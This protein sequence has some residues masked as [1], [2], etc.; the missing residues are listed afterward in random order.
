MSGIRHLEHV[1]V[2]RDPEGTWH[3][4]FPQVAC[5]G[6]DRLVVSFR[7]SPLREPVPAYS[8]RHDHRDRES[9][10]SLVRSTDGGR[11]WDPSTHQVLAETHGDGFIEQCSVTTL[12]DNTLLFDYLSTSRPLQGE[13][14]FELPG[15]TT[16]SAPVECRNYV[17]RSVDGGQTWGE[18][19]P[20][21][22]SPMTECAVHAPMLQLPDGVI[23]APRCG[24]IGRQHVLSVIRSHDGGLTWGD[25]S[26]IATDP[27]GARYYHQGSLVRMPDGEILAAM[28]SQGWIGLPDGDEV[29][30]VNAWLSRSRDDGYT[31]SALRPLPFQLSSAATNIIG[32]QDGRILFVW[33]DRTIPGIRVSV[34]GNGGR[35]WATTEGWLLREGT[36]LD[37]ALFV[38][39]QLAYD[40]RK[41]DGTHSDIGEPGSTQLAD[42]RIM[43]VYYWAE[44]DDPLRRIEA[45]IY[46]I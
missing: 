30:E 36:P 19:T 3:A 17:R 4:A 26:I 10:A 39:H 6:D 32:L 28:H 33:G 45:A 46:E 37:D 11:T 13:V 5:V 15:G 40:G 9:R 27:G 22:P 43:T 8:G 38:H 7:Q 25:G 41:Y 12:K 18:P 1:T 29:L 34:S 44:P 42:G 20:M 35:A 23:L 21:L 16:W 2:Y 14:R 31:W 24:S